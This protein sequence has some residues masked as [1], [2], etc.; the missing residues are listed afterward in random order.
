MLLVK[1]TWNSLKI[2]GS[3]LNLLAIPKDM[4]VENQEVDEFEIIGKSKPKIKPVFSIQSRDKIALLKTV[5]PQ[6]IGTKK[7][8]KTR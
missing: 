1:P 2:Q 8:Y 7:Y 3:G 6:K 4:A 5:I